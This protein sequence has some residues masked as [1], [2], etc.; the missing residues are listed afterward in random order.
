MRHIPCA[1][2]AG[3]FARGQ[4]R[5]ARGQARL[6]G[7]EP[8]PARG[9]ARLAGAEPRP[10]RALATLARA[11]ATVALAAATPALTACGET[12]AE[13]R[14]APAPA[15]APAPGPAPEAAVSE[16][17][18]TVA[19]PLGWQA[20]TE[21][22]TPHLTDPCEE[23]AV[24]TF[25][26]RY[27]PTACAHMPGSALEALGPGDA[28][29]TLEERGLDPS[30][31]WAGFP[32]RPAH[33]GPELGGPSEAA[34]CTPNAHFT[35]HWFTFSDGGRHFHV[36]VAFGPQASEHVQRQAWAILDGLR[37]DPGVLPDW[38]SSG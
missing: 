5:R 3:A 37:V 30:S 26:L 34:A 24:A 31:T 9:Q 18:L 8:R 23:L 21:S 19:L 36:M 15:P 4:A 17:G 1:P 13:P 12:A 38:Q 14:Q 7:A 20:A 27:R 29:V 33:F 11:A 35:D 32:A 16:H 2:R 10:A 6:A 25:P 22:L 28:F